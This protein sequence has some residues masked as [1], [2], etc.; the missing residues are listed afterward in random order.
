MPVCVI[1]SDTDEWATFNIR[2]QSVSQHLGGPVTFVG[3]VPTLHVF[4]VGL[5]DTAGCNENFA[6]QDGDIFMEL[7]V[8]GPVMF[9]ATDDYGEP[10]DVD[11]DALHGVLKSKAL[12]RAH[13]ISPDG[14]ARCA[15]HLESM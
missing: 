10:M 11:V 7:P 8:H 13:D 3:A 12:V 2:H 6:C 4:A 1:V 5:V 14:S 15:T 9:I